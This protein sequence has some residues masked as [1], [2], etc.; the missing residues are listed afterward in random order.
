M[1]LIFFFGLGLLA[2]SFLT[3]LIARFNTGES[4]VWGRSRCRG[5]RTPIAWYDNIPLLSFLFLR[6]RCRGCGRFF[7][8]MYP[9]TELV[10]GTIFALTAAAFFQAH[11]PSTAVKT[12]VYCLVFALLVAVAVYDLRTMEI[13]MNWVWAAAGI[14]V[15]GWL[16]EYLSGATDLPERIGGALLGASVSFGFLYLLSFFSDERWMGYGDAYVALVGGLLTGFPAA[17]LFLTAAFGLG[18]L[19]GSILLLSNSHSL[20]SEIPFAPF[21]VAAVLLIVLL[22]EFFPSVESWL[23]YHFG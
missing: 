19:V 17:V 23:P 22:P 2:G 15:V 13:P 5:C 1:E 9:L 6:G 18:A 8:W 7:G 10:V 14:I 16:F 4:V 21:L 11:E 3:V 20:K 12:V